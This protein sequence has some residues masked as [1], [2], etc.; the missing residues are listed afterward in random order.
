MKFLAVLGLI[1]LSIAVPPVGI[2]LLM[3]VLLAIIAGD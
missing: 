3:V 2:F 1:A